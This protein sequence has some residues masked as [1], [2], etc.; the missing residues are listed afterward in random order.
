MVRA[1]LGDRCLRV[2]H[3]KRLRVETTVHKVTVRATTD[4]VARLRAAKPYRLD[5]TTDVRNDFS[6]S[7]SV[8]LSVFP[9]VEKST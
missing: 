9:P 8:V 2:W 6:K 5:A 7:T 3:W 1:F 4:A